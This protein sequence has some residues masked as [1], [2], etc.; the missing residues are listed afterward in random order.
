MKKIFVLFSFLLVSQFIMAQS[1]IGKGQKQLNAGVGFSGWGLPF[2]V[3]VDFGVHPDISLGLE[4]D[5]VRY[6]ER[7]DKVYYY[8]NIMGFSGNANYH[9]NRVL[10]IP[11][12]FD[13][14]AGL[15]IG[16][17]VWNSPDAYAGSHSSGLGLGAQLGGRYYLNSNVALQLEFNGGQALNGG[18]F[19]I[20]IGL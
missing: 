8:H 10:N 17:F 19:G 12:Q 2:Y 9:F 15:N 6:R 16:F 3:G 14:Y 5:Y 7:W 4:F 18:K 20:T 13:F 1:P 11:K